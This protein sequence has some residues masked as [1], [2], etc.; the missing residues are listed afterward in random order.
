MNIKPDSTK[1]SERTRRQMIQ[2]CDS[3]WY[4]LVLV[5]VFVIVSVLFR[6]KQYE[7][8]YTFW[9][10]YLSIPV[11]AIIMSLC[12][13]KLVSPGW[14]LKLLLLA[15]S[16][17]FSTLLIESYL[18]FFGNNMDIRVV[19]ARASGVR[20]D[21]R[22]R[23][24]I[25]N[26]MSAEGKLVYPTIHPRISLKRQETNGIH[27]IHNIGNREVLPLG[28]ISSVTTVHNRE[29]GQYL[30]YESD[31]HGFRN[32]VGTW[33]HDRFDL[34]VVGD[35]FAH[36]AGLHDGKDYTSLLR[37][38]FPSA[39]NLAY[40]DNGPL[41]AFATVCE[42]FRE[43]KPR[44]VVYFYYE[45]NDLG[46][47]NEEKKAPL[48]MRYLKRESWS[49]DLNEKQG[50]INN[51][52]I[53]FVEKEIRKNDGQQSKILRVLKLQNLRMRIG[54]SSGG[55]K[56]QLKPD[57]AL[58][59]TI[60]QRNREEVKAWGG[61]FVVAYLPSWN[62]YKEPDGYNVYRREV[63]KILKKNDIPIVDLHP[64]FK[65]QVDV[66]SLFH[67][68]LEGHYNQSGAQLVANEV[69]SVL[70]SLSE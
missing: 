39:I 3:L 25:V 62:R 15:G 59:E 50:E 69:R 34:G 9:G 13:L 24:E 6:W 23:R 58:L 16:M 1:M 30:I 67:F 63:L 66:Y 29:S 31:K 10:I 54:L 56:P 41:L 65:K 55:Q 27:S 52:L 47:L 36:G 8:G 44:F 49:Q 57:L 43:L 48:L 42:Y 14:R 11:L 60:M 4:L 33:E 19:K 5:M 12:I 35:S 7:H 64:V 38:H 68:G 28:G 70:E 2:L 17:V 37:P 20:F 21:Q 45:G 22:S 51:A 53:A 40:D 32:P 26:D 18:E 46:N 61:T